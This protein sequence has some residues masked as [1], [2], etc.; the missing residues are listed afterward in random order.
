MEQVGR[1]HGCNPFPPPRVHLHLGLALPHCNRDLGNLMR[2]SVLLHTSPTASLPTSLAPP[3]PS[4][5]AL[6]LTPQYFVRACTLINKPQES[7]TVAENFNSEHFFQLRGILPKNKNRPA[8][9]TR[10]ASE[11]RHTKHNIF[12]SSG[13]QHHSTHSHPLLWK[14]VSIC[15]YFKGCENQAIEEH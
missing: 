13:I 14:A 11:H 4:I 10:K 15:T 12:P 6:V 5:S 8:T 7:F 1:G 2:C 9:R 3:P